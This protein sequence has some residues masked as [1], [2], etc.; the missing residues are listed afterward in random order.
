MRNF[1]ILFFLFSCS[2]P[3][4]EVM[5]G[6][7]PENYLPI[8]KNL[9]GKS[10][11]FTRKYLGKPA[12]EGLCESCGK[13]RLYR[14]IYPIKNMQKF[15]LEI[16]YNTDVELECTVID[17]YPVKTKK[18]VSYIFPKKGKIRKFLRCNQ[19]DGAIMKLKEEIDSQT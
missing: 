1:L 13:D 5:R 10:P 6:Y 7:S 17:F 12:V 15:Y 11:D 3:T 9:L 8:E 2:T 18:T 19:K 4:K 16:T 14:M